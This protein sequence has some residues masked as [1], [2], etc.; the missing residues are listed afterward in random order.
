MA[1]RKYRVRLGFTYGAHDEFKEGDI[2]ELEENEAQYELDK[3][4]LAEVVQNVPDTG[5][6]ERDEDSPSEPGKAPGDGDGD[7]NDRTVRRR[8]APDEVEGTNPAVT[9]KTVRRGKSGD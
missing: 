8:S 5:F 2:V 4:E 6:P 7:G 9:R 3:L 1:V